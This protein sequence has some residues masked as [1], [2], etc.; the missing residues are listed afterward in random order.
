MTPEETQ[1]LEAAI[2]EIASIVYKNISPEAIENLEGIEKTVRSQML[3]SVSPQ[4]A[5][6]LSNRQQAQIKDDPDKSRICV[7]ELS[8]TEKQAQKLGLEPRTH[9]SPVL[10]KCSLRLCAN[11]SYQNA[12]I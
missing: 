9:L 11:E 10:E 7:G 2:T 12:A 5:F 1:R 4:I 3:C 6:F 8:I